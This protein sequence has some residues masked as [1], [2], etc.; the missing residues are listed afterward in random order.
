MENG[1]DA[2]LN[3]RLPAGVKCILTTYVVPK[4]ITNTDTY[5][6][7][8]IV[9][10]ESPLVYVVSTNSTNQES[11]CVKYAFR[12]EDGEWR[13]RNDDQSTGFFHIT[14]LYLMNS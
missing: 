13:I 10:K 11:M 3:A 2:T 5:S 8:G 14:I 12:G 1:F 7:S 6:L 4:Q 9:P